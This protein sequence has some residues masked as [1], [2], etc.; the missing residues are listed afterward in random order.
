MNEGLRE[1]NSTVRLTVLR[2]NGAMRGGRRRRMLY[3]IASKSRQ[4]GAILPDLSAIFAANA[5]RVQGEIGSGRGGKAAKIS[6]L[7]FKR[8]EFRAPRRSGW[9]RVEEDARFARYE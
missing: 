7:K 6:S 8:L 3:P 5:A 9:K 4:R 1:P 2:R